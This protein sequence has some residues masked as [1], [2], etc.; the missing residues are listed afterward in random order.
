MSAR[1]I[2]LMS[3]APACAR[4]TS[5]S[6]LNAGSLGSSWSEIGIATSVD[7]G[8]SGRRCGPVGRCLLR[9]PQLGLFHLFDV[10]VLERD[11]PDLL[12]ES[13]RSIHIP[14]PGVGQAQLEVDLA[15]GVAGHQ[16]DAVGQVEAPLGLHHVAELADN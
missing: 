5:R 14:D 9:Q 10:H 4:M 15:L 7:Y 8:M 6:W 2:T 11:H 16:L 1:P 13:G 12:D 3:A